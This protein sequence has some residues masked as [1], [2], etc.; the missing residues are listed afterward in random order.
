MAKLETIQKVMA[1]GYEYHIVDAKGSQVKLMSKTTHRYERSY[2]TEAEAIKALAGLKSASSA[3]YKVKKA[4]K[5]AKKPIKKQTYTDKEA[6]A[7][8]AYYS[9][10]PGSYTGD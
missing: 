4:K 3:E 1:E 10:K 2:G 9:R 7:L 5:V 6:A 8:M